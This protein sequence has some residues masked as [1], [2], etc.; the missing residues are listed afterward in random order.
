[1]K[2]YVNRLALKL[3]GY[4]GLDEYA[5]TAVTFTAVP[6]LMIPVT[7]DVTVTVYAGGAPVTFTGKICVAVCGPPIWLGPESVTEKTVV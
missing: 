5:V 6:A 4:D 7:F 1:L 3:T 2:S